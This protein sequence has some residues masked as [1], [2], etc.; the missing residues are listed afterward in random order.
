MSD[1]EQIKPKMTDSN[2]EMMQALE[3]KQRETVPAPLTE[4]ERMLRFFETHYAK[5]VGEE[6][7]YLREPGGRIYLDQKYALGKDVGPFEDF[8]RAFLDKNKKNVS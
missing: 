8:Q 3:P 4:E 1:L 7:K 6:M 2:P 5:V